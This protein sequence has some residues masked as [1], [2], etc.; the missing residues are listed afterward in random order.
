MKVNREEF[1]RKLETV[2]PGLSK[3]EFLEQSTSL[4]L[5]NGMMYTLDQEISC[6]CPSGLNSSFEGAVHAKKLLEFLR[7]LNV[8]D[9]DVEVTDSEFSMKG[10]RWLGG[11]RMEK[12]IVLPV[13]E[14]DIPEDSEWYDLAP[15]FLTAVSE[16]EEC[17]SKDQTLEVLTYVHLHTNWVE[18]CDNTRMTR[19]YMNTGFEK[20]YMVKR[21]SIKHLLQLG[22]SQYA[23]SFNWLHFRNKSG[24]IISFLSLCGDMVNFPDLTKALKLDGHP[25]AFPHGIAEECE[26]AGIFS[27][28]NP[29]EDLVRIDIKPLKMRLK[30][31]SLIGRYERRFDIPYDGKELSFLI[32]PK[33][34]CGITRKHTNCIVGENK[35]KIESGN[36]VFVTSLFAPKPQDIP[37]PSSNGH[38]PSVDGKKTSSE[39]Q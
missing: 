29:D 38:S 37:A 5:K 27:A 18:A 17:A 11:V 21:D 19:Y 26:K 3:R 9:M 35:L 39:S 7:K 23:E 1:L 25:F 33:L 2:A 8:S 34:L 16:V 6:R 22:V 14:I 12:K 31:E 24:L 15:E 4:I 13:E 28:D 20:P 30:G 10:K 36:Y 32:S